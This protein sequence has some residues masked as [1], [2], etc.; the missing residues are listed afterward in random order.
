M[1]R[2]MCP[3]QSLL[4]YSLYWDHC[5]RFRHSGSGSTLWS[6]VF[7]KTQW[8]VWS[9]NY[10]I[11]FMCYVLD[12]LIRAMTVGNCVFFLSVWFVCLFFS[13]CLL[14]GLVFITP[15]NTDWYWLISM[16]KD[17][18]SFVAEFSTYRGLTVIWCLYGWCFVGYSIRL[19]SPRFQCV[20]YCFFLWI[21]HKANRIACPYLKIFLFEYPC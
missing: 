5:R 18:L 12:L 19:C 13:T 16:A 20:W 9:Y 17:L 7:D 8:L 3:W 14:W 2:Y 4:W 10:V 1:A 6:D 15:L 21:Y 11:R